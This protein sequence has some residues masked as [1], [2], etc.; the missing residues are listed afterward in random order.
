MTRETDENK[1][2]ELSDNAIGILKAGDARAYFDIDKFVLIH[3]K[4]NY[5]NHYND[6]YDTDAKDVM[7][8]Y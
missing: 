5:Y 7:T 1:I 4:I 2:L 6:N 8:S 3:K